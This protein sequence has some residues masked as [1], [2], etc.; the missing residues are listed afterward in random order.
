MSKISEEDIKEHIQSYKFKNY[1]FEDRLNFIDLHR[2]V[3]ALN[4]V[5]EE[6]NKN[7]PVILYQDPYEEWNFIICLLP[8]DVQGLD[9]AYFPYRSTNLNVFALDFTE[10]SEP[11]YNFAHFCSRMDT[12]F[13]HATFFDGEVEPF[14]RKV[15]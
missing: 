11:Y 9:S 14:E 6:N 12:L 15:A 3:F 4:Y 5:F 10:G 8:Y 1:E 2:E 7:I 13:N